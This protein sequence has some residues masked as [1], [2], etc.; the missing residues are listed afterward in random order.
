MTKTLKNKRKKQKKAGGNPFSKPLFG[1]EILDALKNS[2]KINNKLKPKK[3]LF[4]K[5]Q[6]FTGSIELAKKN[7]NNIVKKLKP[8]MLS[9]TKN[10]IKSKSQNNTKSDDP[11][12]EHINF[13]AGNVLDA[14]KNAQNIF[15]KLN[16]VSQSDS[17]KVE[18]KFKKA[19][20]NI[21]KHTG[22]LM[23][24]LKS[25]MTKGTSEDEVDDRIKCP[26]GEPKTLTLTF[27]NLP[28]TD[29]RENLS[30]TVEEKLFEFQKQ[31]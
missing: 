22:D 5:A 6:L 3:S 12:P 7:S 26:K 25:A 29:V 4:S 20:G 24:G 8:S 18:S 15:K 1:G 30:S 21:K 16:G 23:R 2:K 27:G 28:V 10:K 9:N 11:E 13:F 19:V 17:Q 31:D 14:V